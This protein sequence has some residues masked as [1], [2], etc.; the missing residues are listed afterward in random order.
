MNDSDRAEGIRSMSSKSEEK[1]LKMAEKIK[2]TLDP[3][4][5]ARL[6]ALIAPEAPTARMSAEAFAD[7]LESMNTG[8]GRGFSEKSLEAARQYYVMGANESE[9]A[10][11]SGLTRQAVNA[12]LQRIERHR[13]TAPAG[14]VQVGGWWPPELAQQLNRLADLV[15]DRQAKGQPLAELEQATAALVGSI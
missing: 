15:R 14:W 3:G 11:A 6:S 13:A 9:A 2:Q 12:L 10:K 7:L 5:Q 1:I 8:R 4:E